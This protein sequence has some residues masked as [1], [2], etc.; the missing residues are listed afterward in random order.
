[1]SCSRV[2]HPKLLS[3]FKVLTFHIQEPIGGS[4]PKFSVNTNG[5]MV[6]NEKD[7]MLCLTCPAQGYPTPNFRL[8]ACI[9][10]TL[11]IIPIAHLTIYLEQKMNII[12]HPCI[13]FCFTPTLSFQQC[14]QISRTNWWN[15]AKVLL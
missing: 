1:M 7:T 3:F 13:P 11:L 2:T 8:V 6:S 12:A 14:F 10:N 4:L 5:L 9:S 15:Y